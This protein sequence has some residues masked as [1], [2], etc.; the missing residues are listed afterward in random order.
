MVGDPFSFLFQTQNTS[1]ISMKLFTNSSTPE[2]VAKML[3]NI[4]GNVS[5]AVDFKVRILL[6]L[7]AQVFNKHLSMSAS[8]NLSH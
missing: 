1:R 8:I 3:L 6:I 7:F 5:P 2:K 4:S